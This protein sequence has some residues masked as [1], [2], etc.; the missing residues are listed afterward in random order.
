MAKRN[1]LSIDLVRGDDMHCF[2]IEHARAKLAYPFMAICAIT[3]IGYGWA[4]ETRL[5]RVEY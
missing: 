4:L 1:G 3:V 2:P 5:V